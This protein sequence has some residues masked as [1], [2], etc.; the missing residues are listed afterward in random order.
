MIK[1]HFALGAA[2]YDASLPRE[3]APQTF[4]LSGC[5]RQPVGEEILHSHSSFY[6]ACGTQKT[7]IIDTGNS[8]DWTDVRR[9]LLEALDGRP[10]DYIIP[11]HPEMPHMGNLEPMAEMFPDARIVGDIRNYHL[12]FPD[13]ESRLEM[14]HVGDFLELG[15][16]PLEF[17]EAIIHDLPNS[18]WVYDRKEEVLFACDAYCYTH[19]HEPG[20]C[21][22]LAEELPHEP[23]VADTSFVTSRALAWTQL[24]DPEPYCQAL[25]A[26][27]A[28]RPVKLIAPTHGGVI[29]DTKRMTELFKD[30][31]RHIRGQ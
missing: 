9:Q 15:D 19:E 6:M 16:R 25:D 11:T 31:M 10:L 28:E 26:M 27:L 23:T 21:A 8:R 4:W 1:P 3:I 22:L 14:R 13:L 12:Y 18:L 29:S 7:A 5:S 2:P 20:Q 17:L 24:V 30:G